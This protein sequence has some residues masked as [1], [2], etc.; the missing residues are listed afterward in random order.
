MIVQ[1]DFLLSEFN[2]LAIPGVAEFFCRIETENDLLTAIQLARK[3]DLPFHVLGEGTN[4]ILASKING[5]IFQ[6]AIKGIEFE[7]RNDG[8]LVHIGAG[9]NW[10]HLIDTCINKGAFGLENLSLIPGTVGAAPV[11]NIGAYG[12]EIKD[13]LVNCRVYD[14]QADSFTTLNNKQCEFGYRSSVFKTSSRYIISRIT[15]KLSHTFTPVLRYGVLR[16]LEPNTL[17]A[18]QFSEYIC[19]TR[20]DK[21]P[22]YKLLPNAGSFFKNPIV[23]EQKRNQLLENYPNLVSFEYGS[24]YKLAAG[25]LLDHAGFKGYSDPETGVGFYK[26]QALVLINP[27]AK[28]YELL[29]RTIDMSRQKIADMFGVEL[30]IEP[31]YIGISC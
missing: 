12:V 17:T 10:H 22:D 16:D 30:E 5:Y 19:K 11:Q 15:L 7:K 23:T 9:E 31:R 1:N 21:L 2:S 13:V 25:W 27:N 24:D 4:V 28:S 26:H 20:Q 8:Y 3:N 29:K 6:M 18:K 14:L